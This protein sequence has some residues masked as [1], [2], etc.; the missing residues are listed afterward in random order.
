MKKSYLLPII[1]AILA[2]AAV[3]FVYVFF[4]SGSQ[5]EKNP[6]S[7]VEPDTVEVDEEAAE[8]FFSDYLNSTEIP[9][10]L[11]Q[12]AR[13]IKEHIKEKGYQEDDYCYIGYMF[14]ENL[15]CSI[16]YY[17]DMNILCLYNSYYTTSEAGSQMEV[18]SVLEN[19]PY[20]ESV[21]YYEIYV[22]SEDEVSSVYLEAEAPISPEEFTAES[23]LEFKT[24]EDSNFSDEDEDMTEVFETAE[25][26]SLMSFSFWDELLETEFGVQLKDF[27]FK[28]FIRKDYRATSAE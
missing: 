15:Y 22:V 24:T 21:K 2:I 23:K 19:F 11:V 3:V 27:R 28:N 8:D 26:Y 16:R 10:N 14:G 6:E 12:S 4:G 9:E 20:S 13:E 17:E 18:L 25:K 1:L 5:M 7:T